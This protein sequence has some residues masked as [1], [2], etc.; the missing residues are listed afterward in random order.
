[1]GHIIGLEET[2]YEKKL[3]VKNLVML[4]LFLAPSKDWQH[5]GA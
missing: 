4:S 2:V 3:D 1:M 5:K